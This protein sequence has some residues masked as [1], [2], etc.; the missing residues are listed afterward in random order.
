MDLHATFNNSDM[1]THQYF[2]RLPQSYN[3]V[4]PPRP[5]KLKIPPAPS[6]VTNNVEE[7]VDAN[8]GGGK[9]V[10]DPTMVTPGR[11]VRGAIDEDNIQDA[12][13]VG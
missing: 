1:F 6:S 5:S 10:H 12:S 4:L 8:N 9:L 2:L 3:S 11:S 7:F 13:I